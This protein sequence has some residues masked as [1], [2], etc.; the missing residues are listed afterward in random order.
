MFFSLITTYAS[1][2]VTYRGSVIPFNGLFCGTVF[3]TVYRVAITISGLTCPC[4]G[5][6]YG[7]RYN[8]SIKQRKESPHDTANV[9]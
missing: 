3:T 5:W 4:M 6:L 2:F 7:S 8:L 1:S 9:L